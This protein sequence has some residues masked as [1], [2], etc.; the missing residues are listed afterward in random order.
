MTIWNETVILKGCWN[1]IYSYHDTYHRTNRSCY[2]IREFGRWAFFSF[3]YSFMWP[4][5]ENIGIRIPQRTLLQNLFYYI[6]IIIVIVVLVG[7]GSNQ[8]TPF[9]CINIVPYLWLLMTIS[10]VPNV[11]F[12]FI[13]HIFAYV[14]YVC[15]LLH[16]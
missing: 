12:L 4:I 15:D 9:P 11:I 6:L 3:I 7:V 2:W 10:S 8:N 1:V 13:N 5:N 16:K 14:L